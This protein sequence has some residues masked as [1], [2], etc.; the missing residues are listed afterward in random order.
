MIS[1]TAGSVGPPRPEIA[2]LRHC[3][4]IGTSSLG[5]WTIEGFY[6]PRRRH[7]CLGHLSSAVYEAEFRAGQEDERMAL[8]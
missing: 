7:S 5:A 6:D 8:H 2:D 1:P 3:A 4:P